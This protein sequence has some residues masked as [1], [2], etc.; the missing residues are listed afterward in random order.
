MKRAMLVLLGTSALFWSLL[1]WALHAIA[2]SGSAAVVTVTRWLSLEPAS[3]QW[4][5]DGL[6]LAGGVAQWLVVVIW[7]LGLGVLGLVGRFSARVGAV[8]DSLSK[9][10]SDMAVTN[11]RVHSGPIIEGQAHDKT[12]S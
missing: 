2:G 6:L 10:A 4:I 9:Q 8:H 1:A 3:T 12:L 7:L 5:A 11:G